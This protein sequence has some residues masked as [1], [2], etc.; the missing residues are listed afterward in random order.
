MLDENGYCG[1]DA[2]NI[3]IPHQKPHECD[4]VVAPLRI[5]AEQA[6]IMQRS[7]KIRL[8]A[9]IQTGHSQVAFNI[10]HRN[11]SFTI[12]YV[13]LWIL[14]CDA[15]VTHIVDVYLV[16][17]VLC[18][19]YLCTIKNVQHNVSVV[20]YSLIVLYLMYKVHRRGLQM[21]RIANSERNPSMQHK[22]TK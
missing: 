15:A 3:P 8:A 9:R 11:K 5:M 12:M 6:S 21:R 16:L 17:V 18:N 2:I 20:T 7:L 13:R 10:R 22:V 14:K 4:A 1:I 19:S